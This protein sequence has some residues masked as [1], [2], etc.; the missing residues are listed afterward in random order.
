MFDATGCRTVSFVSALVLLAGVAFAGEPTVGPQQR[1]DVAGG[2]FASNET[3][4]AVSNV[5]PH[6]IV[7]AWNDWRDSPTVTNEVIRAGVAISLNGGLTWTDFVLRPPGPNQS[8]VEGDPMTVQDPRTGFLWAG[9]ISYAGNGG[10]Y[11]A[12]KNPV[13]DFFQPSVMAD[14]GNGIDKGWMVAGRDPVAVDSTRVYIAYNLGLVFSDDMGDSWTN[15]VSL[16]NGLGFLPRIGP[17]G[18]LYIAYWDFINESFNVKRSFDGSGPFT[19]HIIAQ[20]MDNWSTETQNTR[21]PG[22]F[23]VPPLPGL[24]TPLVLAP[25]GPRFLE[26]LLSDDDAHGAR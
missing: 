10:L 21:F 3:S 19:T 17:D 13:D 7:A 9:A 8:G 11:V 22:T 15:P 23:R 24:A 1:V 26:V 25:G 14:N 4:G 2:S 12:R 6:E 16:G 20:R 18:E 5:N